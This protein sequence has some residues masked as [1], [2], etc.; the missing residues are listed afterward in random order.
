MKSELQILRFYSVRQNPIFASV[1]LAIWSG[2]PPPKKKLNTQVH[3]H[4]IK[5]KQFWQNSFS[6]CV[7]EYLGRLCMKFQLIWSFS[8][9]DTIELPKCEWTWVLS[10]FGHPVYMY[11]HW[12][13]RLAKRDFN[14]QDALVVLN[15]KSTWHKRDFERKKDFVASKL[16]ILAFNPIYRD[17][18]CSPIICDVFINVTW[19]SFV[20]PIALYIFPAQARPRRYAIWFKFMKIR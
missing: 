5:T 17:P 16:F 18:D 3:T 10:V 6:H 11:F 14:R 2:C 12:I 15:T 1:L 20:K 9:R 7:H 8:F 13:L 4:K 19:P